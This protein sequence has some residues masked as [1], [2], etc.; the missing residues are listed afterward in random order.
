MISLLENWWHYVYLYDIRLMWVM[1]WII[2]YVYE[3]TVILF[4]PYTIQIKRRHTPSTET[5]WGKSKSVVPQWRR[6]FWDR[7][8]NKLSSLVIPIR[9]NYINFPTL[10]RPVFPLLSLRSPLRDSVTLGPTRSAL[11]SVSTDLGSWDM[12]DLLSKQ[13]WD[14]CSLDSDSYRSW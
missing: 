4:R 7:D 2:L 13:E 14:F 10:T 3:N 11:P 1:Y 6:P 5:C 12:S 9:R 8:Q